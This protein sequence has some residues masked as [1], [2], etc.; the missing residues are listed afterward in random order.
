MKRSIL[1]FEIADLLDLKMVMLAKI[2][3]FGFK[4]FYLLLL[5]DYTVVWFIIEAILS[6]TIR[7]LNDPKGA[8]I[9]L[10]RF[11]QQ[12]LKCYLT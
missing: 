9:F 10:V 8:V 1:I 4:K 5:I 3:H 11:K 12:L 7:A 2:C 6:T